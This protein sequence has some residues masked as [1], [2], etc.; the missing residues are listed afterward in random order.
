MEKK[1]NRFSNWLIKKLH[2]I[3][4]NTMTANIQSLH[5]QLEE[6]EKELHEVMEENKFMRFNLSYSLPQF[7]LGQQ[8]LIT[9]RHRILMDK[10]EL[11]KIT[12]EEYI[13]YIRENIL[14]EF[15]N[16]ILKN[17]LFKFE[18][19]ED[20]ATGM[21]IADATLRIARPPRYDKNES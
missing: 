3:D 1:M 6:S 8:D 15:K 4:I 12:E 20:E 17:N 13:E 18:L 14:N 5:K 16:T 7:A 2:K 21:K 19:I 9:L 10:R 11:Y